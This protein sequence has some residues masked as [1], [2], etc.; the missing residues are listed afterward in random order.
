MPKCDFNKVRLQHGCSPVNLLHIFRTP[1]P[2]NTFGWLLL[3]ILLR[4]VKKGI[5]IYS[6]LIL[7]EKQVC[8]LCNFIEIAL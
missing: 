1:F 7:N 5:H 3:T 8:L 6:S 2:K 4:K